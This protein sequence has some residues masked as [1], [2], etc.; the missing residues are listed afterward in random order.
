MNKKK[1][2]KE[3]QPNKEEKKKRP[4]RRKKIAIGDCPLLI[5]TR[6]KKPRSKTHKK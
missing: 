2:K 1:R 4:G 3:R 6:K 5:S